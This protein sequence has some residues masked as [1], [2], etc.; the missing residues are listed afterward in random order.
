MPALGED[1]ETS[2]HARVLC[3]GVLDFGSLPVSRFWPITTPVRDWDKTVNN[4]TIQ[5]KRFYSDPCYYGPSAVISALDRNGLINGCGWQAEMPEL[6]DRLT[7]K[8]AG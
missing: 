8:L 2:G 5:K 6:T 1:R 4:R 3:P 7:T